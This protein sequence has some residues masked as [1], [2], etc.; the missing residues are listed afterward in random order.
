MRICF[1]AD[2]DLNEEIVFGLFR[3]EA[4]IDFLTAEESHLRGLPDPEVLTIAARE[5]RV[6]ITHDRRTMPYHL[7]DFIAHE[8]SP[9]VIIVSQNVSVRE[10]IEELLLIWTASDAEYWQNRIVSIPL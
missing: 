3:R 1:Q 8:N 2:A 9:G 10:A 4:Q 6:L 7:A 5:N